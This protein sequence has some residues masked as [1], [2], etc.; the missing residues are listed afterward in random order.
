M[1]GRERAR[2]GAENAMMTPNAQRPG[3][4][5]LHRAK[6]HLRAITLLL[7]LCFCGF[8]GGGCKSTDKPESARFASV[9]IH[10]STPAPIRD[11]I[12]AVFQAHEYLLAGPGLTKLV[13]E[14][15]GSNWDNVAY[16]NWIDERGIWVRVKVTIVALGA[17]LSRVEC[18][19]FLVRGRGESTEEEIR[20]SNYRS[21]P[22]Q[23]L[24]D[25]VAA[26]LKGGPAK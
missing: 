17:D 14:R 1:P 9:E 11:A 18:H 7:A 22:Y 5:H 25:E 23:K 6:T 12:V 2:F 3:T 13:F 10:G 4:A 21:G 8:W 16:G 26:R 24:M 20:V 15:K 19:A